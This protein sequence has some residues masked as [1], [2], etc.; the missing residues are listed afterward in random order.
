MND[1]KFPGG[2]ETKE[3]VRRNIRRVVE[4]V[5]DAKKTFKEEQSKLSVTEKYW[6]KVLEARRH[7][8]VSI[9]YL[10]HFVDRLLYIQWFIFL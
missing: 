3:N 2:E 4:S 8:S 6:S 10:W 9:C 1:P 7:F 5:D